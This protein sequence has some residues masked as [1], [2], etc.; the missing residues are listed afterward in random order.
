MDARDK[1]FRIK[2]FPDTLLFVIFPGMFWRNLTKIGDIYIPYKFAQSGCIPLKIKCKI[3]AIFR[4]RNREWANGEWRMG[5][6]V[7][8]QSQLKVEGVNV[9][10]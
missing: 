4:R 3:L 5:I 6:Y 7:V 10:E 8:Q 9:E 2:K 1:Y